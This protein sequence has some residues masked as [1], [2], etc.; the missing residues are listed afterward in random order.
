MIKSSSDFKFKAIAISPI[1]VIREA[2]PLQR[3]G[4]PKHD[5]GTGHLS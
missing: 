4:D 2:P 3:Y 1:I 5:D